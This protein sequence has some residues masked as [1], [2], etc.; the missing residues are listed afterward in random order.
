MRKPR[1]S[2]VLTGLPIILSARI[3]AG[4]TIVSLT[5]SH[6]SP[7]PIGKTIAWTATATDSNTGPLTFQFNVTPP[8]GAATM[9]KDF[10]VGTLSGG[11]WTAP[12]FVWVPTGV[13]G[14]YKI[15]V[16]AKDFVSGKSA[17]KTA[18]F[19][20][21]AVAT[22]GPVVE[23][24]ANPLVAL[25]SAPSCASGS[26][27]R[28]AFQEQTGSVPGSATNW[29]ACHPPATMTFEIAGMY[30]STKYNMH[31]QTNTG[32]K[33]TN[34][35]TLSFTT[36]ALPTSTVT[37]PSF[38]AVKA[39]TD[40]ENPVFLHTFIAFQSE[41]VYPDVAT[42]LQGNII[43]Y[44]WANTATHVDLITRP[45]PGGGNITIQ[46]DYAWDPNVNQ[47]QFLRQVDLAGNI[48]R[49]T[50]MGAIQQEL[51]ALG[52]V[53]GGACT[54]IGT[55][56]PVGAGCTGAFHHDAIQTLP[57]GFTAALIDVE[58][59]FPP[60]TQGD[61][62]GLPVDII[63]DMILVMNTNWQ[64]VWYWDSFD[65]GSGGSGYTPLPVTR[66]APLGE[67]C[68]INSNGCPPTILLGTGIAPLAHDWLH[69]NSLYYWPAPQDG[70]TTGG[71]FIVSSRHQDLVWRID[72]RDGA[73]TGNI[74]WT[75]G[76]PDHGLQ[77]PSDFTFDNTFNDPWP[78]FSHQHDVGIEN[79]GSGQ[80]TIMDNGDTRVS[81]PPLGEGCKTSCYS[82]GMAVTFDENTLVVTPVVSLDL[83]G[84]SS[85]MGSAQLL[86]DGNYFFENAIVYV[87]AQNASLGYSLELG[88]TPAAPEVG[89]ADLILDVGG[90]QHYRGWQ[91]PNLYDPP[92][93]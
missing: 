58:K 7:Q 69:M 26:T 21:S 64:V 60:G 32:G 45:L 68:A 93:T 29:V 6:A 70:N 20:V 31:A 41:P 33:I 87:L 75:M 25:F 52:A 42:D 53:D 54:A 22:G 8:G 67:T 83:G 73:G 24:T 17:S 28:I 4:V 37:F 88:P 89:P 91:M 44:Y 57:N 80:T 85:A 78:W 47:D 5:P 48:V 19:Q 59:I 63:G 2:L 36:G 1:T 81:A 77:P 39:G 16:V 84:Y 3:F 61:S 10:N 46:D 76:P 79:G 9:V 51:V 86:G 13:E 18:A 27:M 35:A 74:L 11:T 15:E 90:P 82:R 23:K 66:T 56:A 55:P 30:P 34:G 14:I 65:P 38:T 50:N 49:E 62:S 12:S 72:Y 40:T 92:T 71:D 43:W